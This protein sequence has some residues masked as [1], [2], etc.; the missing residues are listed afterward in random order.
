MYIHSRPVLSADFQED[1]G[2]GML[3][4]GQNNTDLRMA[5][6]DMTMAPTAYKGVRARVTMGGGVCKCGVCGGWACS[7]S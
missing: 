5:G 4:Y 7:C 2:L 6:F 1:S 3:E